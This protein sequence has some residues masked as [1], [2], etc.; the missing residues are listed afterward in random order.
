MSNIL[1]K[2][3]FGSSNLSNEVAKRELALIIAQSA[4]GEDI[5]RPMLK[6][7][8]PFVESPNIKRKLLEQLDDEH[9]HTKLYWH[10]IH[11]L[12]SGISRKL[13]PLY[14]TVCDHALSSDSSFEL[15]ACILV[16]LE[17]FAFGAFKFRRKVCALQDT[18]QL[19]N[20]IEKDEFRHVETGMLVLNDL[21]QSGQTFDKEKV[22]ARLKKIIMAFRSRSFVEDL[23][24][25]F[26]QEV[27]P[28]ALRSE[29][30]TEYFLTCGAEFNFRF[31]K[32]MSAT[33]SFEGKRNVSCV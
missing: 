12:D 24:S 2:S 29:L 8:L 25:S 27:L 18:L 16:C 15:L 13:S 20:D 21:L 32:L 14:Q 31:K 30:M 11:Q 22:S 28:S 5:I 6:R 7:L 3:F 17:S 19:D 10:H 4:W 9:R 1:I 33:R 26:G 23:E